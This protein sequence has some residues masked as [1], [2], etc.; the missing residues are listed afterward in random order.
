MAKSRLG[1]WMHWGLV[2]LLGG[3]GAIL[4]IANPTL[5]QVVADPSLN[6]VVPPGCTNCPITGGTPV[7]NNLFHSFSR[8][9]VPNGG[10]ADFQNALTVTNIFARITGGTPSNING[11]IRSQGAANLFLMNP[12]GILFGRNAQ[13]N[14]GGS[15]V[16]TTANALQFP[17]GAEFSLTSPVDPQNSL[18]TVNPSAFLFNQI[19][20]GSITNY[21]NT[22][23]GFR[24][25]AGL[26]LSGLRVPTGKSLLLVGGDVTLDNSG[27]LNALGGHIELGGLAGTGEIGLNIL[28]DTFSLSFPPTGLLADVTLAN[29]ARIAV[30][31]AG[32]GNIV[33][34][35]NRFTATD[36][37]RLAAGVETTGNSGNI[38]VNANE[39]LL[40]GKSSTNGSGFYNEVLSNAEGNAGDIDIRGGNLVLSKGAI[41]NAQTQGRGKAGSVNIQ[42]RG[43]VILDGTSEDLGDDTFRTEIT[44]AV[45]QSGEGDGGDIR[46]TAGS[47]TM[48][49]YYA[50]LDPMTYGKGNA[51]NAIIKVNG[52]VS[53]TESRL[54]SSVSFYAEGNGGN[55]DIQAA[56]L[57]LTEGAF[58]SVNTFNK[59]DAG[60]VL[61]DVKK[62]TSISNGASI[63]SNVLSW[64]DEETG[65][66]KYAV[67]NSGK[68]RIVTD[69]LILTNGG[70]I[71]AS[72][73]AQGNAGNVVIQANSVNASG[74]TADGKYNSGFLTETHSA[75]KAGDL[76]LQVRELNLQNQATI[77]ATTYAEGNG[78]EIQVHTGN[79]NLGGGAEIVSRSKG[80]GKAGNVYLNV[81]GTLEANNGSISTTSEKSSGGT[82]S[83]T[84]K[85]IHLVNNSDITTSV[86]SGANNG[87]NIALNANSIVALDDS[88]ILA[89]SQ[90]GKGG[91]ITLNTPVFVGQNYRPAPPGTNPFSLDGNNRVDINASGLVSGIV[92]LPDTTYLQRNM[93]QLPQN[94]I[95]T[96]KL[97]ANSCIVRTKQG[98]GFFVM[99]TGGLATRPGDPPMS[100]FVTGEVRS[101]PD[102]TSSQPSKSETSSI[103]EAE[104]IY[105]LPD[106]QVILSWECRK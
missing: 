90:D 101:L 27:R 45:R 70:Q 86:F 51:G 57:A 40:S 20:T 94:L 54:Y 8:F 87:G 95:D 61:L 78:G 21:A 56:S 9:D 98:A 93:I 85:D 7:G 53:L 89:F 49:G 59:G 35:A 37:G 25:P 10:V 96:N 71:S 64:I 75:W 48:T 6:T 91:N 43:A 24:S 42:L 36:G 77:S 62:S 18:L 12:S 104:G 67:G 26:S 66:T 81:D 97:L 16:A 2:S 100:G 30:R 29:N 74:T 5:A 44:T 11:L 39:I 84:A 82:I 69:S 47:L 105:Q 28:G 13:L 50:V 23:T 4:A 60:N 106:G 79:L 22:A 83:I 33:V 80:T 14:I 102:A 32:G 92:A 63:A 19:P 34:N 41:I 72:T 31:G 99:G 15:F 103:V 46:I 55:V 38:T 73:F 88:D 68:V 65:E 52:A 1:S 58:I 17:G 76:N 3:G